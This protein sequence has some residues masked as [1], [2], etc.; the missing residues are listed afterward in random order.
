MVTPRL[1][2]LKESLANPV[3][4]VLQDC[5]DHKGPLVCLVLMG[6]QVLQVLKGLKVPK[7]HLGRWDFLGS[8]G[9]VEVEV[10]KVSL[11]M[12]LLTPCNVM[13]ALGALCLKPL[14][15]Q[16]LQ[17]HQVYRDPQGLLV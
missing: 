15:H 2:P 10:S 16:D 13:P 7:V 3:H 12:D 11:E 8:K 5:L 1:L 9:Q 6:H 17:V 4:R 14:V